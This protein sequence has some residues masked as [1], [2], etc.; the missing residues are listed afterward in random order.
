MTESGLV[1]P[2]QEAVLSS[3]ARADAL[4]DD[5]N[6][7][8]PPASFCILLPVWGER[9]IRRFLETSLLTLLADGNIPALAKA[10][11]TRFVFLTRTADEATVL[12]HPAYAELCRFVDVEFLSID[13]LI[14]SGNHSTTITLGYERAVRREGA[15]MLDTCFIFLV[16]DYIMANGSLAAVA[17]RMLAGMSAVQ[18]GNFQLDEELADEWLVERLAGAG[19]SLAIKPREMVRWALDC[20]HPTTIANIVNYP[21]CHNS[22][23]NRLFWRVDGNTL[24]GRFYLMHMIS[25]R[26]E[27]QDFVIGSS[28]DYSFVPEM[29]PSGDVTIITDSDEYFVAEVQPHGH[30]GQFIRFGP[31]VPAGLA[32]S[33]S[34]WTTERHRLNARQTVVFHTDDLPDLLPP[35]LAEAGRFIGEVA[36]LLAAPQ[37]HRNHPYWIGAIAALNAATARRDRAATSTALPMAVRATR[38]LQTKL[39]G[40]MPN[41]T[42]AHPRWRDYQIVIPTINELTSE[43]VRRLLI[44]SERPTLLSEFLQREVPGAVSV[45][46]R[47][48]LVGRSLARLTA[49][50][51]DAAFI[52]F[53]DRDLERVEEV[54]GRAVPLLRPGGKLVLGGLR[55]EWAGAADEIGRAYALSMAP[56]FLSGLRLDACH[57]GSA[58]RW[59]WWLNRACMRAADD[60][61]RRPKGYI[62]IGLLRLALWSPLT[63]L[64]NVLS[65]LRSD[66][67]P[68]RDRVI[69]SILI[70]FSL[71]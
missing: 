44:V 51:F 58:T 50:D 69:T 13:D 37:P 45:S 46:P 12:A 21:L 66:R 23:T 26:P 59:R 9:F 2:A 65:S 15:A 68:S 36:P 35:V 22:H 64:S 63:V 57:I 32:K 60:L 43:R 18:V 42:R 4:V 33:L 55:V 7:R 27:H 25:I 30:E 31:L 3:P 8:S 67:G 47:T 28:C 39:I 11:P 14:M 1:V 19:T 70:R 48:S 38:W 41:V 54:V 71:D 52:D 24:I 34:E 61:M 6:R 17:E 5:K 49:R 62:P 29:C 10:L 53:F 56:L 16:S 40:F 20:L